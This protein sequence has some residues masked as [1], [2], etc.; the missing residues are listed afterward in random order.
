MSSDKTFLACGCERRQSVYCR[1]QMSGPQ[2]GSVSAI[3]ICSKSRFW[4]HDALVD[5]GQRKERGKNKT[6]MRLPPRFLG[7]C[8]CIVQRQFS[9][10]FV[11]TDGQMDQQSRR[12]DPC[13]SGRR[14]HLCRRVKSTKEDS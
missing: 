9:R 7:C 3:C 5:Q 8:I 2:I 13:K 12:L 14:F 11:K 4:F 6:P 1:V 10:V